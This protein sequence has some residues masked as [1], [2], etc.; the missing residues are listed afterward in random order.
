MNGSGSGG[1]RVVGLEKRVSNLCRHFL[2]PCLSLDRAAWEQLVFA[3]KNHIRQF[4]LLLS[5]KKIP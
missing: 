1:A 5:L 2:G 3:L 4:C